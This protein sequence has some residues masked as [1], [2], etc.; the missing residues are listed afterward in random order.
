MIASVTYYFFA[1]VKPCA[2]PLCVEGYEPITIPGDCGYNGHCKK[3]TKDKCIDVN[4]IQV[5][6]EPG[7]TTIIP[8][9]KCCPMCITPVA[10]RAAEVA[11]LPPIDCAL[12]RCLLPVCEEGE[13][14]VTPPGQ[15]CPRCQRDC[16]VV[17]CLK[18]V[19]EVGETIEVPDG[20]CCPVCVPKGKCVSMI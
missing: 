19:C 13:T 14:L 12:V 10:K 3:I 6:C 11:A 18:P 4:C 15:C 5:V 20:K 9:G 2:I 17:S 1:A 8:D 7:Q 16:S